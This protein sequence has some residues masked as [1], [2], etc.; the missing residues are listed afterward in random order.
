MNRLFK[1]VAAVFVLA[2][3]V[4]CASIPFRVSKAGEYCGYDKYSFSLEGKKC[5]VVLPDNPAEGRPWVWR[6]RFWGHEPQFDQLMLDEGYAIAHI[7][8]ADMFGSPKAVQIWNKF[9][10]YMVK[11]G[12]SSKV[13]LE[14]MSRG[15]LFVFNWAYENPDAVA[16][17][18]A[19][20]PV[21]SIASWPAGS[22]KGSGST[23]SA[24][25]RKCLSAYGLTSQQ[26]LEYSGNPVDKAGALAAA[27]IPLILVCGDSDSVV[28]FDENGA[29]M[30]KAWEQAGADFKL[31]LKKGVDH[32]PHSLEDP[33]PIVNFFLK[34]LRVP[35]IFGDDMVLQQKQP[36]PVWGSGIRGAKVS[37]SFAGQVK[38]TFVDDDGFWRVDLEPVDAGRGFSMRIYDG[39][40]EFNFSDVAV[41]EVWICS[42]QSNMQWELRD[43]DNYEEFKAEAD[44]YPDL[45]L[46][47]VNRRG[48]EFVQHD[49][50]VD[51]PWVRASSSEVSDFSAIAYH[52]GKKLNTQLGVPV[53]V[54][55]VNQGGSFAECWMSKENMLTNEVTSKFFHSFKKIYPDYRNQ[56]HQWVTG[57]YNAMLKPL[58]PYGI[59]GAIWYQGESNVDA[60]EDYRIVF[61]QMIKLWR[62]EWG[63]GDFPFLY[64]QI[65]QFNYGENRNDNA[66]KLRLIQSECQSIPNTAMVTIHDIGNF[67][68]IHP[69]NKH[70]VGYRL[71][72]AA[73]AKGY[74]MDLPFEGPSAVSAQLTATGQIRI[75]MKNVYAGLTLLT[76]T[77]GF[78]IISGGKV[79]PVTSATVEQDTI[80]LTFDKSLQPQQVRFAW[81]APQ[82]V[83]LLNSAG[84]SAG[85]F[86]FEF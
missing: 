63:Q 47:T 8:T 24:V 50:Q 27:G 48:R 75:L 37:V 36:I 76:G 10:N 39:V 3:L 1:M 73:F 59:K 72:A 52:F 54:I 62:D 31:I 19:D 79:Y 64:V 41:G 53:G 56:R 43:T 45:H 6:A 18:Y 7:D 60:A 49:I 80:I 4:G 25:W 81:T 16:G 28:P 46:F 17:I 23:D 77:S 68:D 35:S 13:I 84:F 85:P 32:H 5:Y 42:G 34:K 67:E 2:V 38:D 61:P 83:K 57:L 26:G 69:R 82:P 12:F 30:Q 44:N 21:C 11:G 20:N 74:G 86:S 29:V 71:A 40:S 55:S 51:K 70:D 33:A 15:G 9:Y 66:A 65:A 22:G 14:G 78:E 58:M